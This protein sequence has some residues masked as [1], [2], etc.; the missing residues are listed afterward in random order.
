M[1]FEI[2]ELF[3]F[4]QKYFFQ[5]VEYLNLYTNDEFPAKRL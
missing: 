2:L 4:S 5:N 1:V 3:K